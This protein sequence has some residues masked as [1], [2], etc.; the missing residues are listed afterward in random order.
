MVYEC[1]IVCSIT[2]IKNKH[3]TLLNVIEFIECYNNCYNITYQNNN[4]RS[5]HNKSNRIVLNMQLT[6]RL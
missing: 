1:Y 3:K 6:C 4:L 2:F 5:N